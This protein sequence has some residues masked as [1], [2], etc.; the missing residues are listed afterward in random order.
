MPRTL[1]ATLLSLAL[2]AP[3]PG[4]AAV[5]SAVV[6]P[7]F[8]LT[9][10]DVDHLRTRANDPSLAAAYVHLRES[11]AR[12]SKAWVK[13]YPAKQRSAAELILRLMPPPWL[14]LGISTQ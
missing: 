8:F 6:A 12:L 5:E 2:A 3:G 14:E 4:L 11:A 13:A 9:P 1:I 7:Q 10:T